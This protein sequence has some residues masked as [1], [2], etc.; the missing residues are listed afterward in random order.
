MDHTVEELLTADPDLQKKFFKRYS[1]DYDGVPTV[2]SYELILFS[3]HMVRRVE[4]ATREDLKRQF[5]KLSDA[6]IDDKTRSEL[7]Y[8]LPGGPTDPVS[9]IKGMYQAASSMFDSVGHGKITLLM[10]NM[11]WPQWAQA[12]FSAPAPTELHCGCAI[13]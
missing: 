1:A 12:R 7:E 9:A 3:A 4:K 6:A 2:G 13:S 10:W 5:P 11:A 8:H